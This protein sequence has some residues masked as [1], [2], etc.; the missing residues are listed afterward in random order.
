M[1]ASESQR[2][3]YIITYS[4]AD[5]EKFRRET[6]GEAII[7]AWNSFNIEISHWVVSMEGHATTDADGDLNKYHFHMAVKLKKRGRWL[8][9]KRYLS[10]K[11][12]IEVHFSDRHNTYYSAYKYVTKS[13]LEAV[14]SVGHPDLTTCPRTENAIASN[15]R[16]RKLGGV[17]KQ[18]KIKDPR[19]S[20]FDVCKLIQQKSISTRL[21][22][23]C[24][25]MVQEREGKRCLAEFI[26]NRGNKAVDEALSLAKEFSHAEEQCLR[27]KKS[28]IQLLQESKDAPC[29]DGCEGRW[30]VAANEVLDNQG[31][32]PSVFCNAIYTALSKGRGKF[33]NIYL[34]GTANSGKNFMLSPLK[35]IYNTFCNPATSSFAW[36]GAEQA[37]VIL[38]NDFRWNPTIIAWADLLQALEGDTIHLPAPK[39]FCLRDIELTRYT[40]FFATSDAP[41]VFIRAGAIDQTNTNMMDIRWSFFRFWKPIS[42]SEQRE[43]A[44][45]GHCFAR[46][47]LENSSNVYIAD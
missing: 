40:P 47:I 8:Q 10:Q 21:E 38:L 28:R 43:I 39:N 42:Q 41:I 36:V 31:I 13:D 29:V 37:E 5:T 46:F 22:L 2:V 11:F 27:L 19:L 7:E 32:I 33:R 14:H 23:V 20:V 6:F 25:A 3:V 16:K 30:F 35:I 12:H 34:Y 17:S 15:K 4:R 45:C 24:L 9:V 26:A 18:R 44:P 1:E